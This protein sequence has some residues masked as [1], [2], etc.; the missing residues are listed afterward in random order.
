MAM[1][2]HMFGVYVVQWVPCHGDRK[3]PAMEDYGDMVITERWR[4][5]EVEESSFYGPDNFPS[6]S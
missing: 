6:E 3:P 2:Q 4:A 1:W 5:R